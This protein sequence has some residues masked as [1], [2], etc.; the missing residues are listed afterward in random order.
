MRNT[1]C[2]K[3]LEKALAKR[4]KDPPVS[5]IEGFLNSIPMVD[6]NVNV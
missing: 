3:Y 4:V 1:R 5:E 2:T 6:V